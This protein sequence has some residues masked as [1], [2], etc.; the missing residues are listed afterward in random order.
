MGEVLAPLKG[1]YVQ[2]VCITIINHTKA[3]NGDVELVEMFGN[4]RFSLS[5]N[6][7]NSSW[8]AAQ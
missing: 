2:Q 1:K 5:V 3:V 6:I 7:P 8:C 4:H